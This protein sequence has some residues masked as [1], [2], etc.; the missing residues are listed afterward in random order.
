LTSIATPPLNNFLKVQK[1][2]ET[3]TIN[4]IVFFVFQEYS[5]AKSEIP[6][7]NITRIQNNIFSLGDLVVGL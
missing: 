1:E 3:N 2:I 6:T 4:E 5:L 7:Q